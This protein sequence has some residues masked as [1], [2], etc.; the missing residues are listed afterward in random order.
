M[1]DVPV[2]ALV[3]GHV[4]S[5]ISAL[6]ANN[7]SVAVY[8]VCGHLT[9]APAPPP[10]NPD[11]LET[12]VDV[13]TPMNRLTQAV[14]CVVAVVIVLLIAGAVFYLLSDA[15]YPVVQRGIELGS[16]SSDV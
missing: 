9:P 16:A 5:S 13:L 6:Y 8:A 1:C 10:H 7:V 3:F 15:P 2:T 11:V 4:P 12:L 14:L